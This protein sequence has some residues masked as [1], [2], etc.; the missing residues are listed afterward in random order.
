M[1]CC[2]VCRLFPLVAVVCCPRWWKLS[3]AEL[4]V[5]DRRTL[6]NRKV[7]VA[8]FKSRGDYECLAGLN[9]LYGLKLTHQQKSQHACCGGRGERLP[10]LDERILLSSQWTTPSQAD[11]VLID[12]Q[13]MLSIPSEE[14][15]AHD[16]TKVK[17][18]F[19]F[20]T[21]ILSRLIIFNSLFQS[22]VSS[23]K[24]HVKSLQ[25][26]LLNYNVI[27]L[28]T[29]FSRRRAA[30]DGITILNS[31]SMSKAERNAHNTDWWC[32]IRAESSV[33]LEW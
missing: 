21:L 20:P 31:L 32:L 4:Q 18:L 5:I 9:I 13:F 26:P 25:F 16:R 12:K 11:C 33:L 15:R 29:L 19:S 8:L 6:K 7:G 23:L 17:L 22:Y 2:F 1:M 14:I 24:F 30:A 28:F 27:S 10:V 3:A